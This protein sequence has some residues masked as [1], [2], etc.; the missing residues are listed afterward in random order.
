MDDTLGPK[1]AENGLDYYHCK[2]CDYATSHLSH[3]KRHIKTKKHL[4]YTRITTDYTL[5]PKAAE[6]GLDTKRNNYECACGKRYLHRQGLYKHRRSCTYEPSEPVVKTQNE[7][8]AQDKDQV[9]LDLLKQNAEQQK[10]IIDLVQRVGNHNT[11]NSHNTNIILQLN[12]NYPNALPIQCLFE[13]IKLL[14]NCVTHDPKLLTDAIVDIVNGQTNEERT[15]HSVKN[16]LYVKEDTGFKED[17]EAEV[18]DT[19]KQET[20]CDQIGKAAAQNPNMFLR[21]K[22]GKE[23]PELVS[24]IMKKLTPGEKK[25][26]KKGI[27]EAIGNDAT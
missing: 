12:S 6:N 23:Y 14:P 7:V 9:I 16:T 25:K 22:E 11:T 19:I 1:A 24:S 26:M 4:D 27:I 13:R 15:I 17:K 5:G 8:V 3:W 2:K 18:F 10:V 21:E 20:E